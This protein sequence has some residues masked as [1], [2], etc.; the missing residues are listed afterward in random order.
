MAKHTP[1]LGRFA[2]LVGMLLLMGVSTLATKC[3][4]GF[5]PPFGLFGFVEGCVHGDNLFLRPVNLLNVMQQVTVN[6]ILAVGMTVV[7][8]VGG[9]DLSVG[10]ML[11]LTGVMAALLIAEFNFA[12]TVA[13]VLGVGALIGYWNGSLAT[14]LR[15]PS[16]I[17]TL[18]MLN[19]ARGGAL[20]LS[21]AAAKFIN[22]PVFTWISRTDIPPLYSIG[23]S[24]VVGLGWALSL[25]R[26]ALKTRTL[27]AWLWPPLAVVGGLGVSL[28]FTGRDFLSFDRA[29]GV[30]VIMFIFA[31]VALVLSFVLRRTRWGRYVYAIG[32]NPEAARRTGIN[33]PRLTRQV[34]VLGS[35][36]ASLAGLILAARL[37]AGIPAEGVA[38]ELDAITAVVIGGTSFTGGVGTIGGTVIG[39]FII[40]IISNSL[41]INGIDAN[42][43]LI[44]KGLIMIFAVALDQYAKRR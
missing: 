1:G 42:W 12:L 26:R 3:M 30:P 20:V 27:K 10:S 32:G 17:A 15:L 35:T 44:V 41:T 37:S 38:A 34:F 43:Q 39:A 21:G 13:V 33:V 29:R 14:Y 19:I 18:G 8:L 2:I 28:L 25:A 4:Q 11:A 23:F 36:C 40:G 24:W 16:F 31:L 6:G 5:E 7:I 22:N 9:I